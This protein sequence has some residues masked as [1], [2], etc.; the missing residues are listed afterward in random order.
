MREFLSGYVVWMVA[1]VL[2]WALV[3]V[4]GVVTLTLGAYAVGRRLG[5]AVA[6]LVCDRCSAA[7]IAEAGD[8]RYGHPERVRRLA[9]PVADAE[10]GDIAES[11]LDDG[12]AQIC[13]E[14]GW[15]E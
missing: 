4:S 15:M 14:L 6:A 3:L 9:D 7:F 12:M 1:D 10:F 11:L 5:A 8:D 13:E 2:W